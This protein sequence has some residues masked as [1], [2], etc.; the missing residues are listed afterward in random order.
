MGWEV[1]RPMG[2]ETR[3]TEGHCRFGKQK[4]PVG[5][6]GHLGGR[7]LGSV[8]SGLPV[9]VHAGQPGVVGLIL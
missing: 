9:A 5:W 3:E 8:C 6:M 7:V 1:G 4:C 2:T